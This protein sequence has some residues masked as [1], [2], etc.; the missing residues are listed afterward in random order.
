MKFSIPSATVREHDR[1]IMK[2]FWWNYNRFELRLE[3]WPLSLDIICQSF[4]G[5]TSHV[6][7][8]PLLLNVVLK[9]PRSY[10]CQF[11]D[12]PAVVFAKKCNI[13]RK[14]I[15][16]KNSWKEDQDHATIQ[17][18]YSQNS[19]VGHSILT[20]SCTWL[21]SGHELKSSWCSWSKEGF[22]VHWQPQTELT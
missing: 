19:N 2:H 22:E 9:N 1:E 16:K 6:F 18:I 5:W 11:F 8:V 13:Q 15:H 21:G 14:S 12:S 7:N 20:S 3:M 4:V 17:V 10:S